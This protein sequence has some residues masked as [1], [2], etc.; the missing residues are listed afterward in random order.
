MPT[1]LPPLTFADALDR[2]AVVGATRVVADLVARPEVSAA[3]DAESSCAG[4]SVGA[5]AYHLA[6]QP[7]RVVEVLGAPAP[8]PHA[9][10]VTV[11]A[12][13]A[14]AAWIREDLDGPSNV[15]VR[16]RSQEAAAEGPESV[17]GLL[18]ATLAGL[19]DALAR[20]PRAVLVPWTGAAM[21]TDDFLVTRLLE[22][23][24]HADDLAS[25]V[26]LPTPELPPGAVVP[27]LRVLTDLAVRRH[28]QAALVRTLSRPQRAPR[29]VSAL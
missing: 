11:D 16:T 29:D 10:L 24:V 5:L 12:H 1:P 17:D 3:W 8:A 27:V 13:Y 4:M 23:V 21:A 20:A 25:S 22:M 7:R 28:G 26:D 19:D 9:P 6:L 18:V 15:G 2:S 14:Q